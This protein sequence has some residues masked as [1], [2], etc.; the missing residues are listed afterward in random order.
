[1]VCSL[2]AINGDLSVPIG[3]GGGNAEA[4]RFAFVFC[5]AFLH[6]FDCGR[7]FEDDLNAFCVAVDNRDAVTCGANGKIGVRKGD[8]W[9]VRGTEDLL[10]FGFQLWPKVSV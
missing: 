8:I 5:K 9:N 3:G 7:A 2:R 4:L 1:M 6:L 10:R